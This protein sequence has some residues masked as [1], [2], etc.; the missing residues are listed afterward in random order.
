MG[1]LLGG[2]GLF[3]ENVFAVWRQLPGLLVTLMSASLLLGEH[4]PFSTLE[5]EGPRTM[6]WRTVE[7][8]AP[9]LFTFIESYYNARRL[10]SRNGYRSPNETESDWRS[11]ALAA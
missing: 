4:L 10:H 5:F 8:A 7:D 6:S 3:P 11:Q 9:E 1:R 2:T